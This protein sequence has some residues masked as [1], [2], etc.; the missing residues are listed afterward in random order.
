[1]ASF[2]RKPKANPPC[3]GGGALKKDK[4][5]YRQGQPFHRPSVDLLERRL[6]LAFAFKDLTAHSSQ[7]SSIPT[8]PQK[9][10]SQTRLTQE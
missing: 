3:L 2:K 8:N 1:M 6:D 10:T 7:A 5:I 9:P 4:P